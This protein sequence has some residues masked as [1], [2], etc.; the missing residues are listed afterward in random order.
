[1]GKVDKEG[2]CCVPQIIVSNR[3]INLF[4]SLFKCFFSVAQVIQ[5]VT[6][7]WRVAVNSKQGRAATKTV[8]GHLGSVEGL[9][10]SEVSLGSWTIRGQFRVLDH[11]RSV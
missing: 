7:Q 8:L 3:I 1:M 9:G 5:Y 11:P 2:L 10:P 4:L 6:L